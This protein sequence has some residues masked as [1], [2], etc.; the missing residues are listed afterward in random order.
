MLVSLALFFQHCTDAVRNI[1]KENF[2]YPNLYN[3]IDDLIYTGLTEDI[4][5]S[6]SNLKTLFQELGLEIS[7]SKLIEPTT[8]AICLGIEIDTFNRTLSIPEDKLKNNSRY[9]FF[10]CF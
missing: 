7:I 2:G 8:M 9:M 3:Y 10:L 4:Y 5:D 1:M 6:Y